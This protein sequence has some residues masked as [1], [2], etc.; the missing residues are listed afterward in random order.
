MNA[1]TLKENIL[2]GA[3]DVRFAKLY[4]S[5]EAVLSFQRARY[6]ALIGE[7]A[8]RYG[9]EREVALFSVPGRSE[10][11]GN[12]TDHNHG[13][14]IAGSIDL[15][16]IAVAAK[17]EDSTVRI[18]SEGFPEDVVD[19]NVF[20]TPDEARFGKSDA[21]IAGVADGMRARGYAVGGY[22][23][24]T[25]SN[26][27]KGSGLSSSAAFENMVG[28]IISHFYNSGEVDFV[29]LAQISQYSENKFFGKPCGLMDQVA[30]A[31]G[32]IVSIDFADTSA[33]IVE[34]VD[35]DMTG[36][37]YS[38]CIVNTG[39]NHAD[40]TPDYAAV[41]AEMKAVAAE[42]GAT[43]LRETNK[44]ELMKNIAALRGKVGDRA[45]LRALHFFAENDR[46]AEQKSAL[47]SGDL[48][49]YF[50]GVLASG[51]SS[52]CYLQNVYTTANVAEQGISLALNLCESYLSKLDKPTAWRVHGGG[53]AGTV[54]AYVPMEDAEGFVKLLESVFGEGSCYLLKIRLSGAVRVF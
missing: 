16:I 44:E 24:C 36:A 54:Q 27:L 23:A 38:L 20:N 21:L 43:V 3:L 7:F 10:L 11:S 8:T 25:T 50:S 19:I 31:A 47:K 1:R 51:R 40:L 53:F 35:F 33:P 2:S 37:G 42:L 39:G 4:G 52:Y 28:L 12:H 49:K 17:N 32:G 6:S 48:A 5:D 45:I 14:V 41:P 9:D 30:C 13:C 46:V 29:T 15:D 34:K 18:K 22:D 26:V